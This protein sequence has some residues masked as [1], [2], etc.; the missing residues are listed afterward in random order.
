MNELSN[1]APR[2]G[3]RKDRKRFGRG[4]GSGHGKTAGRGQKGQNARTSKI[5]PG[6]EGGQTPLI[7]RI[8]IRG[9]N[10][11]DPIRWSII[12]VVE[13]DEFDAGTVVTPELLADR[14]IIRTARHPVKVLGDGDLSKK[15]TVRAHK[16]S[17][18]ALAK[19]AA[20]GG[21][22]EVLKVR[23]TEVPEVTGVTGG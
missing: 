22:T 16:F 23:R 13:L 15:L 8:P 14:G 20:N 1:L 7:R 9:F 4:P 18:S 2:P 10:H 3:A 19:I 11:F 6:F 12:N 21:T 17:K 5:R